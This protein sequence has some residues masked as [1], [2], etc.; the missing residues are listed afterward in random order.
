MNSSAESD[1]ILLHAKKSNHERCEADLRVSVT[2]F[3]IGTC[4]DLMLKKSLVNT[5]FPSH[6]AKNETL[7]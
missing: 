5:A 7:Q 2:H 3:V 6:L 4:L 1:L